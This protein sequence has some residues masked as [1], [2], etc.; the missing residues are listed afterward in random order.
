MRLIPSLFLVA[1]LLMAGSTVLWAG[2]QDGEAA[3]RRGDFA[4][5]AAS[6]RPLAEQGD[7]HA[8]ALWGRM[9]LNGQGVPRN[10]S[11]GL[12]LLQ[13][14][15]EANDPAGQTGL[16]IALLEGRDGMARNPG[17]ALVLLSRAAERDQP[18]ALHR[19]GSLHFFGVATTRNP[20]KGMEYLRR[21]ADLGWP[22][23]CELLGIINLEGLNGVP[24]NHTQAVVWLRKAAEAGLPTSQAL[25]GDRLWHGDGVA[26]DREVA[27]SWLRKAAD[28]DVPLAMDRLGVFMING[29]GLPRD[30]EKG[31]ALLQRSAAKG[32]AFAAE[33]LGRLY[34]F[35]NDAVGKDHG[36]AIP[37]LRQAAEKNRPLSQNLLGVAYRDGDGV[38][39][40]PGEAV[41]WFRRSAER[42]FAEAQHNLAEAYDS[43][44]G[45][46]RDPIE[47]YAWHILAATNPPANRKA[48]YE[49]ARDAAAARLTQAETE[50][51]RILAAARAMK[52]LPGLSVTSPS[53]SLG[54][55]G[56]STPVP[57]PHPAAAIPSP[58]PAPLSGRVLAGSGFFVDRA[59]TVLTN[60]HVV[61]ACRTIRVTPS[62][63]RASAE[64][65]VT[66]RDAVNDL[67]VLTTNLK[68]AHAA[69]FREDKP[70]RPG[71][72]VV[73]IGYPLSSLLSREPNVTAGGISAMAG[74]RGDSRFYQITAPV[75]KGNSGGPLADMSGNVVGVVSR[76]LDAMA[77][78][79]QFNDLPE[80]VA[81]AL[82]DS[83]VRRFLADSGVAYQTAPAKETLSAADVGDRIR[84]VTVFIEC[85][86]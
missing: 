26:Q 18:E 2:G 29:E 17:Q 80:N 3:L 44:A 43:G 70:M 13:A 33:N 10:E 61:A 68:P 16:A 31:L 63:T 27:L 5:A 49:Q 1:V 38:P 39:Q 76:K 40:S 86:Q 24:A 71:D 58:T 21:A 51:A 47:S 32:D 66:A 45:V 57:S 46:E 54:E 75:Q 19:L 84:R 30:V 25:Y 72:S 73:V 52:P 85:R 83:L 14:S 79:K 22:A 9:L 8:Q 41:A 55:G 74:P 62:D 37:L 78:Q 7:A 36:R 60:S 77:V 82:K 15:A 6:L 65:T 28:K 35:G 12:R 56:P 53:P 69:H 11:E 59:G 42:G 23:A 50:R 20:A 81:F 4:A 64:A 67:A 48:A 34:W